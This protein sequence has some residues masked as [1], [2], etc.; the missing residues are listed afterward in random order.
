MTVDTLLSTSIETRTQP[1][2]RGR[3]A[4]RWGLVR[5][6]Q[7]VAARRGPD[8]A[9]DRAHLDAAVAGTRSSRRS[10][11]S[12]STTA[13]RSRPYGIEAIRRDDAGRDPDAVAVAGVEP[14]DVRGSA[15]RQAAHLDR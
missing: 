10:R 9:D 5:G 8:D 12:W 15:H 14:L 2:H 6:V 3:R 11:G 4:P 13:P 7:H 1:G